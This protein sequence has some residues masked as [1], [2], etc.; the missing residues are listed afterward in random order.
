MSVFRARPP[1]HTSKRYRVTA[2]A[3]TGGAAPAIGG[4]Q[5]ANAGQSPN[6][7]FLFPG[8][9]TR[10]VRRIVTIGT[11]FVTESPVCVPTEGTG[12]IPDFTPQTP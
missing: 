7:S 1:R 10:P 4:L 8:G 9:K 11:Q 6:R 2:P 3:A 12:G 5:V